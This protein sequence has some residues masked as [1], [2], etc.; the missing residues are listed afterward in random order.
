MSG[1]SD[2][3]SAHYVHPDCGSCN[4]DQLDYLA[5]HARAERLGA[6]GQK[7]TYCRRCKRYRWP[8]ETAS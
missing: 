2:P 1:S 6:Q 8:H 3:M 7:Q 5:W 4:P